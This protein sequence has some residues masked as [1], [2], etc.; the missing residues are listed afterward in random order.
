MTDLTFTLEHL[1]K[2]HP[3]ADGW[4]ML[5][6]GLKY[7]PLNTL[8]ALGDVA[9][10]NGAA[11]A[12]WSVRA[13]D[14]RNQDVRMLVIGILAKAVARAQSRPPRPPLSVAGW[15]LAT[16]DEK[17]ARVAQAPDSVRASWYATHTSNASHEA[18]LTREEQAEEFAMQQSDIIMASAPRRYKG[19]RV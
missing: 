12:W 14:W 17:M 5:R 9:A 13:V 8:I 4:T 2:Y 7:P 10:V 15:A 19:V 3:C 18:E 16:I 1:R 11:D 6:R